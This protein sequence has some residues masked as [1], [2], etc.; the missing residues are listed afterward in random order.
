MKNVQLLLALL[1]LVSMGS[2]TGCDFV[3]RLLDKEGAEEKELVGEYVPFQDNKAVKEVQ[4]LLKL[5]G[6]NPGRIDG[7]LG[8][9][10]RNTLER[11]QKGNQLKQTRFI[12]KETWKK[13]N[14][15]VENGFVVY[16][17]LNVKLLQRTLKESGSDPGRVDGKFGAKTKKAVKEFQAA[18]GLKVDGKVGYK[19]LSQLSAYIPAQPAQ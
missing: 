13:L 14:R 3:Y 16:F 11:F 15:F 6:Y 5:Y 8:I 2:F 1:V 18:N 19:T 17:E 12:D 9:Q 7:V 4:T 10:T